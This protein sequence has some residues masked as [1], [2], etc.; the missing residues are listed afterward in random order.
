M[1]KSYT[2]KTTVTPIV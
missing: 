2:D 1:L